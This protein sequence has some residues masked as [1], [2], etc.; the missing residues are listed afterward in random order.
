LAKPADA[1]ESVHLALLPEPEELTAGLSDRHRERARKWDRLMEVREAVL[2]SLEAAR[3]AKVI[4]A[5]L[6]AQVHLKASG[7]LYDLLDEYEKQLADLFIVS[8]V[9]LEGEGTTDLAIHVERAAGEK[10]PRCWK[11]K[12]DL[13]VSPEIPE[14]CGTCAVAI[15]E[16][17]KG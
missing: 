5:P 16:N 17:L 2:K 6:E 13:G 12:E 1:P 10:C 11:Y 14:V 3:A 15:F 7:D 9:S 8:Q 4:G